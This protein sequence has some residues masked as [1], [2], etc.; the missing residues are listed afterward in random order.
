MI[1]PD[2]IGKWLYGKLTT[3]TTVFSMIGTKVFPLMTKEPQSLPWIVYDNIEVNYEKTKDQC[4]ATDATLSILCAA[5]TNDSCT[6]LYKAVEA[7]INMKDGCSVD[8]MVSSYDDNVG[9][10]NEINIKIEL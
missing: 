4:L 6:A 7:A 9:F 10:I 8:K 1:Y 5:S 2:T 3:D